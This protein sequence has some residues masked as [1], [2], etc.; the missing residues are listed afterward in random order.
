MELAIKTDNPYKLALTSS[1]IIEMKKGES[2]KE[3]LDL[4]SK[5]YFEA[6]QVVPGYNVTE[7]G[8]FLQLLAN[9]L[10]EEV[11]TCFPFLRSEELK[12]AFK[13]GVRKDY[14]EVFGLNISTFNL[15]IK[16]FLADQ[17]RKEAK[18]KIEEE[19]KKPVQPICTPDEAEY[20]WRLCMQE[21]FEE[22]KKTGVLKC[23]FPSFQFNEFKKRGLINLS[24]TDYEFILEQAKEQLIELHRL[25]RLNPK[26]VQDRNKSTT[27]IN[28]VMS[29]QMTGETEAEVK[30]I[31]RRIAI[32]N[33]YNAIEKLEL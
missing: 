14:G 1:K 3:M 15:W 18:M 23:E 26:S 13:N 28:E 7:Q 20:G 10:H 25:K 6:G 11:K 32:E 17:R 12:L 2:V 19:N 4:L 33:Y 31:A 29:G 9:S 5:T 30:N 27:K 21:Q 24:K 22:F 16:G 8:K